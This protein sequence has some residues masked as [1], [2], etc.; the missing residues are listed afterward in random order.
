MGVLQG[1][2][3]GIRVGGENGDLINCE[4]ECSLSVNRATLNKSGSHGGAYV[5]KRYG[6][7]NWSIT[8][9]AKS[10][11]SILKGSLNN[12]IKYQLEGQIIEVFIMARVSNASFVK[13]GG[14]VLIPSI[15]VNFPNIGSSKFDVTFEGT[16]ELIVDIE[17]LG[18]IINEM[19]I[20]ADKPLYIDTTKW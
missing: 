8:A 16:G 4:I 14:N 9:N 20:E 15:N 6:Y 13:I 7:I 5:H 1:N 19:P 3:Y 10:V 12:L 2:M 17:D 11:I 18:L